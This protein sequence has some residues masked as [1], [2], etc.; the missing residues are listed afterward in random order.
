MT[1]WAS[2]WGLHALGE[3]PSVKPLED[4]PASATY[5]DDRHL[6]IEFFIPRRLFAGDMLNNPWQLNLRPLVNRIRVTRWGSA[7]L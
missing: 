5:L 1:M 3:M 2:L 7:A 6:E 4:Y